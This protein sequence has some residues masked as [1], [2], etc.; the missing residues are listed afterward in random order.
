MTRAAGADVESLA[1]FV[2]DHAAV[3]NGRLYVNGGLWTSWALP[4]F[5]TPVPPFSLVVVVRV[6]WGAY[7][8]DHSFEVGVENLRGPSLPFQIAGK[9][10]AEI[11]PG[12]R[13]GDPAVIPMAFVVEG[14]LVERPGDYAFVLRV[15]GREID[16]Y[17]LRAIH[18]VVAVPMAFP[19]FG[20]A[21]SGA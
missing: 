17:P 2:A 16:R 8:R 7:E 19:A 12:V 9:F 20:G 3:E 14:M 15:E 11:A 10:R 1:F 4:A 18:Q 6:P 5:P 13:E 21:P